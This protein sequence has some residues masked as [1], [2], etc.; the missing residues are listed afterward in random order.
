ME[1]APLLRKAWKPDLTEAEAR[2]MLEDAARV[3]YYR[4]CRTIK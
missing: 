4:D 2:K 1:Q 3:L